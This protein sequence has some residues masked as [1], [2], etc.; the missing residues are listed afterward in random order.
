M[1][2]DVKDTIDT[3]FKEWDRSEV[4]E[5]L[6]GLS[7]EQLIEIIE[8]FR[9]QIKNHAPKPRIEDVARVLMT[10]ESLAI[11]SLD[12]LANEIQR[13]YHARGLKCN[14]TADSMRY[15][16]SVKGFIPVQRKES[17]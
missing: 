14:T 12:K 8:R 15:Y 3:L 4:P 2:Q 11:Y 9:A 7:R 16:P 6:D 13:A 17:K 10:D 1:I 5:C